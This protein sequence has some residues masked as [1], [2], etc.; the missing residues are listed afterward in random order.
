MKIKASLIVSAVGVLKS[1]DTTAMKLSTAYKVKTVLAAC[2]VAIEDF[3]A[4]R[5][6]M[7]ESHGELSEDKTHYKFEKKGSQ[8]AFQKEMQ[9]MLD[10]EIELDIK[11]KIPL[12]LIDDYLTIAPGNVNLV[13]WFIDGL[14]AL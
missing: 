2:S 14:D 9:E 6:K 4:K 3:E 12:E 11:K 8:E 13:E 1:I 10:D 7:A 5:V